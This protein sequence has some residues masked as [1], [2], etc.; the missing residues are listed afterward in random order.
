MFALVFMIYYFMIV[1]PQ[2]LKAKSQAD[3]TASLKKGDNVVTSG[4][5]YGRVAA[6]ESDVI[7]IEIAPNVKI[8]VELIH[9]ARKV[10]TAESS[11]AS[12]SVAKVK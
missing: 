3:L 2:Q 6:I 5:I 9:I 12:G 1:K 10:D 7:S 8:K 11:S 4:G